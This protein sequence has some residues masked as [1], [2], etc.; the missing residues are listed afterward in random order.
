MKPRL[1]CCIIYVWVIGW[2]KCLLLS[3]SWILIQFSQIAMPL[4]KSESS[5]E[6]APPAKFESFQ[7]SL[8]GLNLICE[9]AVL[10]TVKFWTFL[11]SLGLCFVEELKV[12]K[13]NQSIPSLS[14]TETSY[15]G[16]T[17]Y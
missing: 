7:M 17:G 15:Y 9:I 13:K 6:K 4:L 12:I 10:K 11:N 2:K 8:C 16:E 3:T 5:M 1:K 14:Y